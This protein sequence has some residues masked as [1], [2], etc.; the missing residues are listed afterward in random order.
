ML[1]FHGFNHRVNWTQVMRITNPD[2]IRS[3]GNL[4]LGGVGHGN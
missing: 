4:N 3:L 2:A 1:S